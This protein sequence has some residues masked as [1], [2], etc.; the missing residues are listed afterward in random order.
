MKHLQRD[1]NTFFISTN[2]KW[3][4]SSL[5]WNIVK[6]VLNTEQHSGYTLLTP[7][8]TITQAAHNIY[9]LK[10]YLTHFFKN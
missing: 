2:I 8:H 9:K 6:Q 1:T 5:D 7:I 10:T 4:R 3:M